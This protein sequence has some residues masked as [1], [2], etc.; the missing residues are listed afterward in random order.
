MTLVAGRGGA[1]MTATSAF[2][3]IRRKMVNELQTRRR[4]APAG[5]ARRPEKAGGRS[6]Q[7]A[8]NTR[9]TSCVFAPI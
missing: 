1:G 2:P 7:F 3:H 4:H 9:L 6:A 8:I 5:R